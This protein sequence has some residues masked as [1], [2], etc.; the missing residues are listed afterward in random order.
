MK[1][2][3]TK[4]AL[5]R[6]ILVVEGSVNIGTTFCTKTKSGYN[7]YYPRTQWCSTLEEAQRV[8]EVMRKRKIESLKKQILKLK[9]ME[10]EIVWE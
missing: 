1:A 7:R 3:V 8:A 10:I 6:G 4:Y 9:S 5:T 2:Y